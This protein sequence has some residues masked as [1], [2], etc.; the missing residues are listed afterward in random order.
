M[1]MFLFWV[2]CGT[3]CIYGY[4]RIFTQTCYLFSFWLTWSLGNISA[5]YMI[6]YTSVHMYIWY[7][8]GVLTH[9]HIYTCIM[10]LYVCTCI[11]CFCMH[12][13]CGAWWCVG[14]HID[15]LTQESG[16]L[17]DFVSQQSV[18]AVTKWT[19]YIYIYIYTIKSLSIS[20]SWRI[21]CNRCQ[22]AIGVVNKCTKKYMH[23]IHRYFFPGI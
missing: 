22:V 13:M 14:K 15:G 8:Y 20:Y 2:G 18:D 11:L 17:D 23:G 16:I 6:S 21:F 9:T 3:V 1:L 10:C 4:A 7:L 12:D 19:G 5:Y